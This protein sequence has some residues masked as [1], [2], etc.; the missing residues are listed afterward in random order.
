MSY[1]VLMFLH[2]FTVLPAFILGTISL[3]LKKGTQLHK[4]LGR[5]Y[6]ILM[7]FTAFVT[8]FMPAAVGPSLFNHFGWIHLFSFLTIYTVP[9]AYIAIKK[10]NIKAH[11][12]KMILLYF[13]ALI[14]AGA[15]TFMP[16]RYLHSVF[17]G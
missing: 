2:L 17:F 1:N 16:G 9:T 5:I 4:V 11:K 12:R 3:L 15:F 8:L 14:I 10:G 6:M 7:L 13:G